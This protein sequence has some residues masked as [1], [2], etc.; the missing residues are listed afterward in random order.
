[1]IYDTFMFNSE[2]DMLQLRL[3]ACR[4]AEMTHVLVEAPWTHRGYPKDLNFSLCL[5]GDE[6]TNAAY[7]NDLRIR[8]MVDRWEPDLAAPW[9]NEH[10]QRNT[11]WSQI[12]AEAADGDWVLICDVDEIPN[13]TLLAFLSVARAGEADVPDVFSVFMRTFLFAV[14]WEVDWTGRRE[15]PTCVV[16]TAGYLREMAASGLY[17]AEV[18]DRRGQYLAWPGG[19][20]GWHFSWVGGPEV[21]A[22]KLARATCHTEILRTPEA[23]LIRSGARWR[24]DQDGG[25]LPVRPV[26][27]DQT[28]PAP[29]VEGRVPDV[30][31]RPKPGFGPGRDAALKGCAT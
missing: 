26:T 9:V 5:Q 18:R 1:M 21:Q 31:F 20:G 14:D 8:P 24:T 28:W 27:V 22:E 16:A 13:P 11:A 23:E 6:E 2:A 30:W 15:P 29:I 12:N 4:D 19:Y 7:L 10:H 3:E 25:G 17:L